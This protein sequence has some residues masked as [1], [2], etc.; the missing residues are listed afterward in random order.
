MAIDRLLLRKT[1]SSMRETLIGQL[2][3]F[4]SEQSDLAKLF[5]E[6]PH[7]VE[8]R[9]IYCRQIVAILCQLVETA[10]SVDLVRQYVVILLP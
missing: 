9:Y 3:L 6:D 1:A 10:K 4:E 7:V 8:T 5:H 2:K